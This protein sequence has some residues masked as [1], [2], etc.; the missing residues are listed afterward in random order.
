[1]D[2]DVQLKI[3]P[4]HTFPYSVYMGIKLGSNVELNLESDTFTFPF[5]KEFILRISTENASPRE[6]A[7][8]VKPISIHLDAF[9]SAY[10]AEL[11]GKW[12]VMAVLWFAASKKVTV[13]FERWTGKYPFTV[14]DRTQS[15]GATLRGEAR[16]YFN[17]SPQE[18][19][20]IAE[21]AFVA[22][23]DVS[24]NVLISMSFYASARMETTEQA[25]FIGLMTA[26]ESLSEQQDY[27]EEIASILSE[28]ASQLE[29]SPL[30]ASQDKQS[31][32][33]SLSS[34]VRQ[35]RQE[36]VRQAILRTVRQHVS[37]KEVVA[38]VDKAYGIRSKILHE[39]LIVPDSHSLTNKLEGILRQIYASMMELPLTLP[40]NS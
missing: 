19:T 10:E 37:D 5:A 29:K 30:L 31:L 8:F 1:M 25:R 26:L 9:S 23:K 12:L 32:R 17:I 24:P 33:S 22:K 39:G 28:L 21:T 34:R 18:F 27:G 3:F 40:E 7:N 14:R 6:K 15:S 36:S 13:A 16:G 2:N 4:E 38:W 20:T 11:A 35:L